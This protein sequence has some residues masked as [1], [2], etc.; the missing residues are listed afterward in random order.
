MKNIL[1]IKP[2][3]RDVGVKYLEKYFNCF[4]TVDSS[5]TNLINIVNKKEI[6][7][8]IT[9]NEKITEKIIESSPTLEVIGQHGIGVNN[10]NVNAATSNEVSVINVP[11]ATVNSVAEH[12]LMSILA[13]SR[14]LVN[15]HKSVITGDW[16]VRERELPSEI[17]NKNLFIIGYG[18]I[19]KKVSEYAKIFGMNIL[20]YDPFIK[21]TNKEVIFVN[22]LKEGLTKA[23]YTSIHVPLTKGTKKLISEKELN[24]MRTDSYLINVSRGG[25][26]DQDALINHIT[27]NKIAGAQLDVLENEP[28]LS[29]DPIFEVNNV[30]F[31]S[32]IAGDTK[33]AKDRCSEILSKEVYAVLNGELSTN[34]VNKK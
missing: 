4:Y 15:N 29:N 14:N 26:V 33:E 24:Y 34:I 31:T 11:N 19:G 9:R 1:F 28:P 18:A 27:N 23:D 13:L 22:N 21:D 8:I 3:I 32:H 20:V 2:T 12:T 25:V 17:N 7:A 16:N 6:H 10:I 5:E 30:I